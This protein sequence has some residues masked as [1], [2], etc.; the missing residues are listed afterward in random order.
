MKRQYLALFG[1]VLLA[2]IPA[3]SAD[4]IKTGTSDLTQA[5][6]PSKHIPLSFDISP[7]Y[8][9]LYNGNNVSTFGP[10]ANLASPKTKTFGLELIGYATLSGGWQLGLGVGGMGYSSDNSINQANYTQ[11]Y[12]GGWAAKDFEL[13]DTFDISFGALISVGY[14]ET[15][16]YNLGPGGDTKETSFM[17]IPRVS[18][19]YRFGPHIRAGLSGSWFIPCFETQRI[20]GND[21]T[22]N[23][24]I[25]AKGPSGGADLIFDFF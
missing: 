3:A 15:N 8:V 18:L 9:S 7:R 5:A 11:A 14:A 20:R 19:A 6:T 12:L 1:L 16:L 4:D 23:A 22:N 2:S 13:S 21:L 17:P 10:L 25:S 24:E